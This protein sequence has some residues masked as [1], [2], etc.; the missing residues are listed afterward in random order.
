MISKKNLGLKTI[1]PTHKATTSDYTND[2]WKRE[3]NQFILVHNPK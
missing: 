1:Q 2:G 3:N